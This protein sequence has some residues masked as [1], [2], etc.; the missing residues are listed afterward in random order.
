MPAM[1][2]DET[3]MDRALELAVRGRGAV[4]PNPMVGAVIV[5]DGV[6]IAAGWHRRFGGPHAEVEALS[7]AR[8]SGADVRGATVYVTLEP[9][10]HQGKTPPCTGAL[11][12]AGVG[13]VVA[14]IEDVD[15]RVA[16]NGFAQLREAGIEV[17]CG[18][19][20]EQARRLLRA[21]IKLRT[22]AR[23][24]VICK[25]AQTSDGYLLFPPGDERRWISCD[26]ARRK[27]HEIRSFCDGVLAGIQTVLHD[28]PL[29]TNRFG[30]G[31]Q[32]ARLV[33][34]AELRTSPTCN[35]L[36]TRETSPVIVVT[37][38]QSLTKHAVQ[39]DALRR[40]GA[41][42]LA[43]P[44]KD[45]L[46]GL[47]ELLDELGRRQW[48][49]LLVEGG[50]RVHRSFIE[51]GLADELLVFVSPAGLDGRNLPLLPRLDIRSLQPTLPIAEF[52]QYTLDHDR[53]YHAI[54]RR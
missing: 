27:V 14:A 11:I 36:K 34:D 21:Y 42:V 49:Y 25:W 37:A 2:Q 23:P 41:E 50:A 54:L 20:E 6:E 51:Q 22:Q 4:E 48:T 15:A 29:L 31:R 1:T 17:V 52:E 43:L 7:A 12:A 47:A 19:R 46:L 24:W 13:K 30:E 38:E 16:G 40:A 44:A 3:F 5:R 26:A 32:P 8:A 9:C 10:C 45:G 53:V 18:V 33:L 28:D 35:L 39:A